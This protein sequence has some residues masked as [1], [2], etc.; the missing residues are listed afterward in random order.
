MFLCLWNIPTGFSALQNFGQVFKG[1]ST[2]WINCADYTLSF[3]LEILLRNPLYLNTTIPTHFFVIFVIINRKKIVNKNVTKNFLYALWISCENHIGTNWDH[4]YLFLQF[5]MKHSKSVEK[6]IAFYFPTWI[7]AVFSFTFDFYSNEVG[8]KLGNA[9]V[10]LTP[11]AGE[12][13]ENS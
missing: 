4:G 5:A 9:F 11:I 7:Q 12:Y 6:R 8:D 3:I 1:K 10:V 13:K 2:F